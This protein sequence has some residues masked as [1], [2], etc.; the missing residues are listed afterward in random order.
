MINFWSTIFF[1]SYPTQ[2]GQMECVK[3]VASSSYSDKRIGYLA[4]MLLVDEKQEVLT[5]VTQCLKK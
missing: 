2:W 5:L 1:K 3:L 4:L